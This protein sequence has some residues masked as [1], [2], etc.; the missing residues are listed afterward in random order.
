MRLPLSSCTR[1]LILQVHR[2]SERDIHQGSDILDTRGDIL[3][4]GLWDRHTNTIIDVKLSNANADIYRFDPMDQL[5]DW[6]D[7]TNKDNH[8]KHCH[9][10]GGKNS[11]FVIYVYGMLG[12]ESLVVLLNLS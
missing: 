11:P 9:E 3:I 12:R 8:G 6:W 10:Q 5:R 4:R 7:K 1:Q 2:I